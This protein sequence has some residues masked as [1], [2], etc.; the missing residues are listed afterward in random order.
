MF[1][2]KHMKGN[3]KNHENSFNGRNNPE[4]SLTG[5]E[6]SQLINKSQAM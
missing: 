3:F 2:V 6:T 5:T 4:N 1:R